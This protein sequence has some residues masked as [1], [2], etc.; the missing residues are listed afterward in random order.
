MEVLIH[1]NKREEE[2][3]PHYGLLVEGLLLSWYTLLA[4]DEGYFVLGTYISYFNAAGLIL[5]VLENI[6][7]L[8]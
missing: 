2:T 4:T 6:K 7:W 8:L 3:Y 1:V 5:W